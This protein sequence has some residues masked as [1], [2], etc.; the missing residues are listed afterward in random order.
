M[1]EYAKMTPNERYDIGFYLCKATDK[2]AIRDVIK[3]LK[4][5]NPD[6]VG[7]R[8]TLCECVNYYI[9]FNLNDDP[10]FDRY[11]ADKTINLITDMLI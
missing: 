3:T 1:K 9:K 10:N 2:R 4:I 6:I 8:Y 5:I 7:L 11:Q